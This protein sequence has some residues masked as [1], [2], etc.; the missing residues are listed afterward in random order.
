MVTRKNGFHR[1]ALPATRGITQGNLVPP[2]LFNVV[3]DNVITTWMAMTVEEQKVAHDG[4]GE[5]FG[6]CLGVFYADDGMVGS[7]DA[8]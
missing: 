6:L 4:F 2:T 3:V 8:K 1:T 5:T 7:R